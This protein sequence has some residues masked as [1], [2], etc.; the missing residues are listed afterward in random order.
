MSKEQERLIPEQIDEQVTHYL[1][2][3][4]QTSNHRLVHNVH[5][6]LN[7]P[8]DKQALARVWNRL[9]AHLPAQHVEQEPHTV[10]DLKPPISFTEYERK[11]PVKQATFLRRSS[12]I[13][14]RL[15]VIASIVFLLLLAGS[16]V[17]I[18]QF[19]RPRQGTTTATFGSSTDLY[20]LTGLTAY[21]IDP[22]THQVRWKY[23]FPMPG[24]ILGSHLLQG[25]PRVSNGT[26]YVWWGNSNGGIGGSIYAINTTDGSLRWK[27]KTNTSYPVVIFT[28]DSQ[29]YF[30]DITTDN[31]GV[32][33]A[34]DARQGTLNWQW[35][36]DNT[37]IEKYAA[38][39]ML[40]DV[41]HGVLYASK[42]NYVRQGTT[43][44]NSLTTYAINA[45]D[46]TLLWK[47]SQQEVSGSNFGSD[48]NGRVLDGVFYIGGRNNGIAGALTY[49]YAYDAKT[50]Q[51][52]WRKSFSLDMQLDRASNGKLYFSASS[53]LTNV[54]RTSDDIGV[55]N[56]I[57]ALH[58]TDGSLAW[59]Y[60]APAASGTS[61]P[62]V[63]NGTAYVTVVN[64]KTNS[65][66]V[67]A[68]DDTTGTV[69]WS[70]T[71]QEKPTYEG[72]VAVQNV[73]AVG[74]AGT[75]VEFL[76]PSDGTRIATTSLDD[77]Y[78]QHHPEYYFPDLIAAQ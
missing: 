34:L 59:A 20:A 40:Q 67:V 69:R 26:Y 36:L 72:V 48:G 17:A 57:E 61:Y 19:V 29:V 4:G 11:E 66:K 63:T 41:A 12:H 78:E 42:I 75:N 51:L 22:Q 43:L 5:N 44:F 16:M 35:K 46:G 56:M 37:D 50:G 24:K 27:Y 8:P 53:S 13:A 7:T 62:T 1:H 15:S 21:A 52:K 6:Y 30:A 77:A 38:T 31:Q 65:G 45:K 58:A 54:T 60:T 9:D 74:G 3:D 18:F 73:L 33:D 39:V 71:L 55:P 70:Q 25:S 68:L 64:E 28:D 23:Q 2:E 76:N 32:V 14:N 49:V 10:P 47:R